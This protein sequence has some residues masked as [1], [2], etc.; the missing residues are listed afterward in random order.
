MPWDP[1]TNEFFYGTLAE[2]RAAVASGTAILGFAL[3][4]QIAAMVAHFTALGAGTTTIMADLALLPGAGA[5]ASIAVPAVI[6][7][8]V[9]LTLGAPYYQAREMVRSENDLSGFTHGFVMGVLKWEWRHVVAN[10][11]RPF[12]HINDFDEATDV[13]RVN[14]YHR[15]LKVGFAKGAALPAD[16]KKAY[17]I[18]LRQLAGLH[19]SGNWSRDNDEARKQQ[20]SYVIELAAAG[21]R[22]GIVKPS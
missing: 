14:A 18:K 8:T 22:H 12:I 2:H 16:A 7:G 21:R 4:S 10:F 20:S 5:A 1:Q 19:I 3:E 11:R 17:R 9:L 15:G 6:F 13:I